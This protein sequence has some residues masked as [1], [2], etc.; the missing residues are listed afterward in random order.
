MHINFYY[1]FY[2]TIPIPYSCA[3]CPHFQCQ[4]YLVITST[5]CKYVYCIVRMNMEVFPRTTQEPLHCVV[6]HMLFQWK[7]SFS[8]FSQHIC[9]GTILL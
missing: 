8:T 3:L 9:Y 1:L 2:S 7:E 5:V 4:C 6:Q